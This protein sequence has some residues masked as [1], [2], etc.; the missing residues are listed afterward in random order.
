MLAFATATAQF[1]DHLRVERRAS[2]NTR[3]AYARDL[4]SLQ[5]TLKQQGETTLTSITIYDL[6]GWLGQVGRAL[7]AASIARKVAAIRSFFRYLERKRQIT[8]NPAAL[9]LAPK[10]ARPLPARL[11]A[12]AAKEVVESPEDTLRGIRD[13]LVLELLY[14][15]GLRVA[16]LASLNV[17]DLSADST[18]FRVVGKGSKERTLPL[19]LAAR[20]ALAEY[21][22]VRPQFVHGKTGKQDAR[23]LLLSTRGARLQ[24]RPIQLLVR[25]YGALGAGRPD[26]HPHALRHSYATHLLDGGADLRAI[27]ELL[28]HASLSTTQR[29]THVSVAHLVATYDKAHPLAH[30]P[31]TVPQA[32]TASPPPKRA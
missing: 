26:L 17:A 29:Y 4:L 2:D 20:T 31:T 18:E 7:Q 13:R 12:A 30:A 19:G 6:R 24:P 14:G 28:G 25:N 9:L 23:A 3:A 10:V 16:E 5:S 15:T 32:S 8:E 22:Q 11:S 21:L 1:L 27:Q